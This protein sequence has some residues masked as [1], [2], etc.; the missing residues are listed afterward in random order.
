MLYKSKKITETINRCYSFITKKKDFEA[1]FG[2]TSSQS[3]MIFIPFLI[4]WLNNF[5]DF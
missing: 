1:K 3:F 4:R 5:G 2:Y